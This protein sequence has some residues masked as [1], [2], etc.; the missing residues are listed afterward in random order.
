MRAQWFL[1]RGALV[2]PGLKKAK[3]VPVVRLSSATLGPDRRDIHDGFTEST[4]PTPYPVLWGHDADKMRTIGAAPNKWLAPRSTAGAGRT[5]RK[6]SL[7]WPKAGRLL[8]AERMWLASQRL[9]AVGLEENALANV[10][11]PVRLASDDRRKEK[12]LA[13]WLNSTLGLLLMVGARVPTRGPSVQFKKPS[14]EGMFILD[15]DSLPKKVLH[16]LA[17]AFDAVASLEMLPLSELSKDE[18][19]RDIDKSIADALDLPDLTPLRELLGREPILTN[20]A[21][22]T[23]KPLGAPLTD[24]IEQ[25][26]LDIS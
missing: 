10:W 2:L 9:V 3:T 11:W 15:V 5:L 1:G 14:L 20:R 21:L 8:I 7:L 23:E 16:V 6:V 12:V 19:R 26:G 22:F 24:E 17:S 13:L 25:L 18:V 4:S